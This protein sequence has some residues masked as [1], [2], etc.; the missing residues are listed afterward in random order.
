[1]TDARP[2]LA[3]AL[4]GPPQHIV[5]LAVEV[6]GWSPCRSKRGVVI[7]SDGNVIISGYNYKP[8]GFECDG[9]ETC[10]ATCRS[11]AVHAEQQALLSAGSRSHASE[12]IHVKTVE[13]KIVASGGPSCVECSKLALAA[14]IAWV[15]LYH[16]D[17][18]RRYSGHEFHR[19]SLA[20][21]ALVRASSS[22]ETS[23]QL[24]RWGRNN[25][26]H[27]ASEWIRMD[28]GYWTPWH[29]ADAA[30]RAASSPARGAT[31]P[32]DTSENPR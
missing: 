26:P 7:F 13:G 21:D 18:W 3:E 23:P 8:R 15:W 9:S 32:P 1:M 28:D 30:L 25:P 27:S 16:E 12:M 31:R 24:E 19:L 11:E 29:L 10:K 20:E 4:D 2:P 6:S 22:V 17:G 5:D 14:G